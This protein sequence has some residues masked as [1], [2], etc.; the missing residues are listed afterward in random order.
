MI[1][2]RRLAASKS[3]YRA[4]RPIWRRYFTA[5]AIVFSSLAPCADFGKVTFSTP[6]S[7]L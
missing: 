4:P 2:T 3:I 6:F 5:T 7:K 1:I